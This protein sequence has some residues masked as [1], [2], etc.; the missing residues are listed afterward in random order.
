MELERLSKPLPLET[1][2]GVAKDFRT[3]VEESTIIVDKSLLGFY[4]IE[5]HLFMGLSS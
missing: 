4:S 2:I 1:A 3:L 5:C